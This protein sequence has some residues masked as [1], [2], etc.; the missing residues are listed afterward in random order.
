MAMLR[1]RR[2]E[3]EIRKG[4]CTINTWEQFCEEFTKAFFPN[5][6][7][8]EVKNKFWELKQTGSIWAYVKEFTTLTLEI[9]NLRRGHAVTLH[10]RTAELGQDGVVAATGQD[11]RRSHHTSRVLDGLQA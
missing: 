3:A 11:H 1:W 2:K 7:V 10:G 6:V 9:L 8:Y 4:T 5:N